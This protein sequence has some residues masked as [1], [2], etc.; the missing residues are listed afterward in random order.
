MASAEAIS[1]SLTLPPLPYEENALEPV[2]SAKTLAFHHGKHHRG[3]VDATNKL[4]ANTEL[5]G[6]PLD[7]V[8]AVI[9]KLINWGFAAENLARLE[10]D[11]SSR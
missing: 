6:L 7:H 9:Q 5:A 11:E 10:H 1:T 8:T 3:Y 2:I 4:I